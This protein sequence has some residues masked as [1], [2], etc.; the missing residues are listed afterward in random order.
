[1]YG[2]VLHCKYTVCVVGVASTLCAL[3]DKGLGDVL[4]G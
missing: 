4:D 3:L 2:F 1:M